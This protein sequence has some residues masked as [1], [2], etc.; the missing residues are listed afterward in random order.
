MHDLSQF[1]RETNNEYC[2]HKLTLYVF[3][4]IC[5]KAFDNS[6]VPDVT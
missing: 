3:G 5:K 6:G 4:S 2:S 1:R